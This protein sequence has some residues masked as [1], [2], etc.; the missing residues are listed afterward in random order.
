MTTTQAKKKIEAARKTGRA[1]FYDERD[2]TTYDI[3]YHPESRQYSLTYRDG[4]YEQTVTV[5][6]NPA[7]I[8]ELIT[9]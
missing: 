4:H 1:R 3:W 6:Y 5:T 7:R 9:F 2:K 8:V